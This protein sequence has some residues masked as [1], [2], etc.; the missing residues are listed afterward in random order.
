MTQI[1]DDLQ[2]RLAEMIDALRTEDTV[3]PLEGGCVSQ[4]KAKKNISSHL[5]PFAA[6]VHGSRLLVGMVEED[7]T[8]TEADKAKIRS[9]VGRALEEEFSHLEPAIHHYLYCLERHFPP[10]DFVDA[11]RAGDETPDPDATNREERRQMVTETLEELELVDQ[12]LAPLR[13]RLRDWGA[14]TVQ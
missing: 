13:E 5:Y 10:L 12:A 11:E 2:T 9:R 7:E 6:A 1:L 8:Y 4:P 3:N 14:E